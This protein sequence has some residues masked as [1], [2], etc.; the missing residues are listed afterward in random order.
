MTTKASIQSFMAQPVLAVAG[1]SR[2]PRKFGN[3]AYR[4]LKARGYCV[5]PVNPHRQTVDGDPCYPSLKSLPEQVGG[6]LIVTRPTVAEQLVREAAELGIDHVWLQPGAESPAAVQYCQNHG[7]DA[8]V[9]ECIM[10]YQPHPAFPHNFHKLIK[11][12]FGGRPN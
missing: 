10:M 7:V 8:V 9:G 5:L 6:L 3:L 12:A 4:E 11:H 2:D 1:V